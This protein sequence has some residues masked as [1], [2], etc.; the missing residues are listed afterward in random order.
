MK[1]LLNIWAFIV[2]GEPSAVYVLA[3]EAIVL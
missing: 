2:L 3:D 1:S